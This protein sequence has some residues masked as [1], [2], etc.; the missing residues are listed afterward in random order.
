MDERISRWTRQKTAKE[1]GELL[2]AAGVSGVPVQNS[3]D[4]LYKDEHLKERKFFRKMVFPPSDREPDSFIVNGLPFF[5]NG[6]RPTGDLAPA[7]EMGWDT[8]YVVENILGKSR[9]WYDE[10]VKA[11]AFI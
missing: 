8:R 2:Q 5:I 7:P 3:E 10:A 6:Y 1:V 9:E 11:E 4:L